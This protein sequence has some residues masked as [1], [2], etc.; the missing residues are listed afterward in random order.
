MKR[1][2]AKGFALVGLAT[3]IMSPALARDIS[4]VDAALIAE[5]VNFETVSDNHRDIVEIAMGGFDPTLYFAGGVPRQGDTSI[6]YTYEGQVYHFVTLES[7]SRFAE[8][9]KKYAPQ[10]AGHCAF[11]MAEHLRVQADPSAFAVEDG[12]L[13]LFENQTKLEMWKT[14]SLKF[15][16]VADKRWE[17]EA[18]DL[19]GVKAKF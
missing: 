9:P 18:K 15:R 17:L 1:E 7:R 5:N 2:I 12:K 13:F 3:S 8:N 4:G 10:Y 11:A 19:F 6:S 16:V 14:N